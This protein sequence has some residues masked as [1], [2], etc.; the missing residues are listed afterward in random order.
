VAGKVDKPEAAHWIAEE[1]HTRE[2]VFEHS[3]HAPLAQVV[4]QATRVGD[5]YYAGLAAMRVEIIHDQS[6]VGVF[7]K[8]NQIVEVFEEILLSSR[9]VEQWL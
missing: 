1:S 5:V 6:P 4:I 7:V 3:T 8:R 9:G 2:P